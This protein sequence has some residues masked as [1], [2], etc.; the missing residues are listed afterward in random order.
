MSDEALV[1][2][3]KKLVEVRRDGDVGIV[4]LDDPEALNPISTHY[5]G[6]EDQI[7][8][9]V[10]ELE[11]EEEIRV[12]V[13]GANGRA[14]SSGADFR[15]PS[16]AVFGTDRQVRRAI[17][18]LTTIDERRNWSMWYVLDNCSK[19]LIAAVH[20]W[21]IGGGWE[22]AMWCDMVIA[23]TTA[24]FSL[25][26]AKVG[27]PPAFATHFLSR[28]CGRWR[29]AELCYTGKSIDAEEANDLGFITRLV[30][31][32]KDLEEA[33]SLAH[34]VAKGEP[35]LLAAI[36]GQLTRAAISTAEWELNRRDFALVRLTDGYRER[37]ERWRESHGAAAGISSRSS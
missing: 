18:S 15:G 1:R 11:A 37:M 2:A 36:R 34:E 29:A 3:E 9:A 17:A 6:M 10:A 30:P 7:V 8:D 28:V 25:T 35:A 16:L 12:I 22:I 24:R 21:A 19:P 26:Q 27:L 33:V 31:E 23:D 14:F 4:L 20:G 5:G 32:G 13:I